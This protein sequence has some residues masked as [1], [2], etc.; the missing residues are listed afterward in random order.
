MANYTLHILIERDSNMQLTFARQH[1]S[2]LSFPVANLAAD[3]VVITGINGAG[4]SHLLEAI[5]NGAIA[6]EGVQQGAPHIRLFHHTNMLPADTSAANPTQLWTQRSVLWG[7]I[8]PTITQHQTSIRSNLLQQGI[9]SEELVDL[10]VVADWEPADI[11]AIVGD[12]AK[13]TQI[14]SQLTKWLDQ[15][16]SAVWERWTRNTNR[17]SLA[18]KIRTQCG[19]SLTLTEKSFNEYVP[20]DWNPTD[21]FQQNFA[22]LFATYHRQREENKINQYYAIQKGEDRRW[23]E[24]Q[25]FIERYGDPPWET[26]NEILETAKLPLRVN[27]PTGPYDQPFTLNLRHTELECD[28]MYADL[29]SGEK[30]IISLA[31][32][33]Y[34]ARSANSSLTLPQV[35]LLDE[36]DAPLHPTMAKNFMDVIEQ[37]LVRDRG[38][39]VIMTTHSPSTVAFAPEKSLYRLDRSP[40]Q[41]VASKKD[42]AISILTDGFATVMPSTRFVIVE[43]AFDQDTYQALYNVVESDDSRSSRP[44]LTFVRASDKDNRNGGGSGQVSN[45]A[46]KLALSGLTFFRGVLDRDAGNTPSEV[47]HV[48]GRYSI[49][50]YL[51]DP[52]ILYACLV[53]KNEH[54]S[55][56]NLE[57][58]KDCNIHKILELSNE[59]LQKIADGVFD[60]VQTF[61]SQLSSTER[62]QIRY[63][64]G[65][66][67]SA[68]AWLRDTRGHD[69][70]VI[71]RECFQ[72][73]DV[74]PFSKKLEELVLMMTAKLPGFIA[75]DL[76]DL[77]VALAK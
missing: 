36:P 47:V 49:E 10:A 33:L 4:K 11:R 14:H 13:A 48:L 60:K 50:N 9:P 19:R 67:I 25:Q 71:I 56:L 46:E 54:L 18:K 5:E 38:V 57:I 31:H 32:C 16:E 66:T 52:V 69:L 40:R 68:P 55:I 59:D 51:L 61:R 12:T 3:F 70:A 27:Y 28:V 75:S 43:A 1:K 23:I 53:E 77:F 58:L 63:R 62:F 8:Q 65:R 41:L 72:N 7:E 45:W 20:L 74:Y 42:A 2:I 6:I 30:I 17:A 21:V 37:V 22:P 24:D 73:D 64:N 29:S 26:I 34:Y 44:P 76:E 35:L 39:K 15:A